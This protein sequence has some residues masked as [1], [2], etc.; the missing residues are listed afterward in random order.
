MYDVIYILRND[1]VDTHELRYSLR[2]LDNLKHGDVWIA[3]GDPPGII[4]DRYLDI[5]QKGASKWERTT[6]TL[7]TI[8]ESDDTPEV[9]Y[10]FND[11]FFIMQPTEII[12]P[13]YNGTIY[14]RLKTIGASQYS[15][16]LKR[17]ADELTRRGLSA[18]NY[19][20]HIPMLIEK[21][22]ALEVINEFDG[23]PMFRSLYGNYW[24]VGGIDT[25]DVKI[26]KSSIKPDEDIPYLSTSNISFKYGRVGVHIR[27]AFQNKSKYE[28]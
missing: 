12:P 15:Q 21:D 10:L 2:S 3:G 28:V 24:N 19:A 20:V 18:Y 13:I 1:I 11:D 8:C 16:Q 7:R 27:R 22:K 4:P 17:T 23:W 5:K 25:P 9:F 6:Y 14:D 26:S